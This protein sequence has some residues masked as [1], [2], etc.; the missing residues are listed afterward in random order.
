MPTSHPD[1]WTAPRWHAD[2]GD[3]EAE[4]KRLRAFAKL[5]LAKC[6]EAA[7]SLEEP[8]EGY[9]YVA[10]LRD[11]KTVAEIYCPADSENA[12]ASRYAVYTFADDEETESY[13][14]TEMEAVALIVPLFEETKSEKDPRL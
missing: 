6:P 13:C 2:W 5:L 11:S 4:T 3:A 8:E 12:P 14:A 9:M 7:V 1:T 10:V